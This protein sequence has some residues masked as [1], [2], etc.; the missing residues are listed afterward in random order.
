MQVTRVASALLEPRLDAQYYRPDFLA[1]EAAVRSSKRNGAQVRLLGDSLRFFETGI[2]NKRDGSVPLL[3]TKSVRDGTIF[4]QDY[5]ETV[6]AAGELCL[7]EDDV[8]L[9]TYGTG[10]IG[11]TAFVG[12]G[13]EFPYTVDYTI[14][15][16]R[17]DATQVDPAYLS[18]FLR[19]GYGQQQIERHTKGTTGIT[20]VLRSDLARVLVP[21][22]AMGVQ[23][24][25]GKRIR[26]AAALRARADTL[27]REA[28]ALVEGLVGGFVSPD[29]L[30]MASTAADCGDLAA[31]QNLLERA[32]A[33]SPRHQLARRMDN[34]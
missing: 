11:K 3:K 6:E 24:E 14:A 22:F 9:C 29:E 15:I 10:S 23:T 13:F 34:V 30:L 2:S 27:T 20:F 12:R 8:V 16:L 28:E 32:I 1:N 4:A 18:A 7:V 25:V 21:V 26:E 17:T 19:S 33:Q 31:Q 5:S